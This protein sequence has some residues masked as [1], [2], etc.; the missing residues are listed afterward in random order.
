M[1]NGETGEQSVDRADLDAP[2]ATVV[3]ESRRLHVVLDLRHDDREKR[4]IPQ[5]LLS[6]RGSLKPLKKLL[7]HEARRHDQ[8]L[9]VEASAEDLHLRS[10]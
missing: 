1:T 7:D 5:D 2:P 3:P 9:S 8:V 10:R 4:E 6:L